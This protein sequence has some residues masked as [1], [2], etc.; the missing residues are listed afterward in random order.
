MSLENLESHRKYY[1]TKLKSFEN[2]HVYS[3]FQNF[4]PILAERKFF[5]HLKSNLAKDY[6]DFLTQIR[7][8]SIDKV[9]LGI[10]LSAMPEV[11]LCGN[12]LA[13][14][15]QEIFLDQLC[16]G[17]K[18]FSMAVSEKGW[19]GRI[20]NIKT[21]FIETDSGRVLVGSK[22]FATNGRNPDYYLIVTK[23][24]L[25]Y[26]SYLVPLNTAGLE[27]NPFDLN[28]AQEATHAEI[29]FHEIPE[30]K[31]IKLE[32][33]YR[34]HAKSLRLLEIF[35]LQ[36][37]LLGFIDRI[38]IEL[39]I[40]HELE[41]AFQIFENE[42]NLITD[43]LHDSSRFDINSQD[44]KW[45]VSVLESLQIYLDNVINY[46]EWNLFKILLPNSN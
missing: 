22:G 20:K 4:S 45:G 1:Q 40:P 25:I 24:N 44:L 17:N 8:L 29:I 42:I 32:I 5:V 37:I 10:A 9:G 43:K 19:Q 38:R 35:S 28:Y 27:V 33:D 12:M 3:R 13:I 46:P 36:F 23:D 16:D 26:N 2:T 30:S 21:S 34:K 31:L 18:I 15:K 41:Q 39:K 6:I 14:A 7:A 11:N